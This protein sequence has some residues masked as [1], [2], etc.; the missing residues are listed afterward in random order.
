MSSL[1]Q[2][3]LDVEKGKEEE[4]KE[5]SKEEADKLNE[6]GTMSCSDLIRFF[7]DPTHWIVTALVA[8]AITAILGCLYLFYAWG[9]FD[10][11]HHIGMASFFCAIGLGGS[12]YSAFLGE[13][14]KVEVNR[15]WTL[16]NRLTANKDRLEGT[17]QELR[18]NV[19]KMHDQVEQFKALKEQMKGFADNATGEFKE[20]L[21]NARQVMETMERQLKDNM[22]DTLSNY[23]Q[24]FELA[25]GEEGL[26]EEEFNKF[27]LRLPPGSPDISFADVAK[28]KETVSFE[29]IQGVIDSVSSLLV[30]KRASSAV[31]SK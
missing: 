22:S 1:Q 12:A 6:E 4:R 9:N 10:L 30:K 26:N 7:M 3:L 23:A 5:P 21:E 31:G 18:N 28:G 20:V 8:Y 27:K 16:N 24:S 13:Q 2:P 17:C 15:F 25:D 29:E 19:N 11:F 14:L